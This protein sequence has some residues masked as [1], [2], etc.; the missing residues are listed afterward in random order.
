MSEDSNGDR[1]QL[2]QLA[3]VNIQRRDQ[4][5]AQ[6]ESLD[7]HQ[8]QVSTSESSSEEDRDSVQDFGNEL[9]GGFDM[10]GREPQT[11]M[12]SSLLTTARKAH[13]VLERQINI[14][15]RHINSLIDNNTRSQDDVLVRENASG[16]EADEVDEE[17]A[18]NDASV[19]RIVRTIDNLN[20]KK[21][22]LH[23]FI[24]AR[25]ITNNR[26]ELKDVFNII[27]HA[28]EFEIMHP[29]RR[30]RPALEQP[31]IAS[32][33]AALPMRELAPRQHFRLNGDGPERLRN[34][35]GQFIGGGGVPANFFDNVATPIDDA[36]LNQHMPIMQYDTFSEKRK[37]QEKEPNEECNVCLDKFQDTDNIRVFPCCDIAQHSMC[38]NEWFREHDTCVV[39]RAKLLDTMGVDRPALPAPDIRT[40][41]DFNFMVRGDNR[42][43]EVSNDN[44]ANDEMYGDIPD[45]VPMEIDDNDNPVD[46]GEEHFWTGIL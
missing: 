7:R 44:D 28:T 32:F 15:N 5:L 25:G 6:S 39:C 20:S 9:R 11:S 31:S 40:I 24:E 10:F 46:D 16:D 23:I 43:F 1:E 14:C 34:M 38:L 3:E 19:E 4:F 26:D 36:F 41:N 8:P 35:L 13:T 17:P 33:L 18:N 21:E 22:R 2:R 45:L 30:A 29:E 37:D 27:R 42:M 12:L